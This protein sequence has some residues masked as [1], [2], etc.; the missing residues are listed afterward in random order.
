MKYKNK[1]T[2]TIWL[3]TMMSIQMWHEVG[4][5]MPCLSARDPKPMPYKLMRG[6]ERVNIDA[7][8]P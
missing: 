7:K 6:D 4:E 8:I 3:P 5:G 1:A 2:N